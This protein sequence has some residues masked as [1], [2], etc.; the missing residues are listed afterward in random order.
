LINS[1]RFREFLLKIQVTFTILSLKTFLQFLSCFTF[2][3]DIVQFELIDE[4]VLFNVFIKFIKDCL[5]LVV[6]FFHCFG[7]FTEHD[8]THIFDSIAFFDTFKLEEIDHGDCVFDVF[9]IGI[10]GQEQAFNLLNFLIGKCFK[11]TLDLKEGGL[12]NLS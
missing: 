2:E 8:I 10:F 1:L 6:G 5:K 3:V 4:V 11:N 7:H 12:F 9:L